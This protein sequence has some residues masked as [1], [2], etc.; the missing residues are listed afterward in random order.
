[1]VLESSYITNLIN[2]LESHK[3]PPKE[4]AEEIT[5]LMNIIEEDMNILNDEMTTLVDIQRLKIIPQYI[6]EYFNDMNSR[7]ISQVKRQLLCMYNNLLMDIT[8][9][10]REYPTIK[11][12][13]E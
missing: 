1:M 8:R 11:L 7:K 9:T 4:L 3:L 13:M 10:I 2:K 6:L 12:Y 5:L